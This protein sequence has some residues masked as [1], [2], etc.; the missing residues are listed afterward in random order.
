[1]EAGQEDKSTW[2]G[3]SSV[4]PL[5]PTLRTRRAI[6]R[7]IDAADRDTLHALFTDPVV[8]R[9]LWDDEV[10]SVEQVVEVTGESE[11]LFRE[12]GAGLWLAWRSSSESHLVEDR[13]PESAAGLESP[14]LTALPAGF[15]GFWYF[16]E[17]PELE[18]IYGVTPSMH[19]QGI[20]GEIARAVIDYAFAELGH[21]RIQASMDAPNVASI[22]V[23]EKLG[24]TRFTPPHQ[25]PRPKPTLFFTLHRS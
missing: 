4:M 17:P 20:A 13:S 15:T 19:G 10:I 3:Q 18:L 25:A 23:A 14:E 5:G 16:H 24:M 11:R 7:P 21:A 1:M 2:V 6:L 8:R 22:R 9:Y 12:S